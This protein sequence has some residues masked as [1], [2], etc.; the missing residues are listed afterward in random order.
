MNPNT[1][2][3]RLDDAAKAPI[4][5]SADASGALKNPADNNKIIDGAHSPWPKPAVVPTKK[6]VPPS[7]AAKGDD[8]L[9]STPA[10]PVKP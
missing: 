10:K 5:L 4:H 8:D 6:A 1:H 7:T 3:S 2:S 9:M